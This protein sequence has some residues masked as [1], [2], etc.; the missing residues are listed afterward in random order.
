[1]KIHHFFTLILL[2]GLTIH[3]AS[4]Q[5]TIEKNS[6]HLY[7]GGHFGLLEDA[8]F[9]PLHY[10]DRSLLYGL[11]YT[12]YR[13]DQQFKVK[14]NYSSGTANTDLGKIFQ[15][16]YILGE[17]RLQYLQS[18]KY[19]SSSKGQLQLGGQY[20]FYINY[21][22]WNGQESFSFFANHSFDISAQ[23]QYDLNDKNSF[24]FNLDVPLVNLVV[25]PPYNGEDEE[26]ARNNNETRI[27]PLLTDGYWTSYNGL[28]T[29]DFS[30]SYQHQFSERLTFKATYR[31]KYYKLLKNKQL[32][33]LQQ[34]LTVGLQMSF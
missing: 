23:Y 4:G 6:L 13:A 9:S 25:R 7:S 26:L 32:T 31:N 22:D 11:N 17:F 24:L 29:Y 1:M 20:H 21:S 8:N 19:L 34:Q 5:Q 18:S 14:L 10:H 16:D 15:T 12:R 27:I 30:L 3:S 28:I 2:I 33:H